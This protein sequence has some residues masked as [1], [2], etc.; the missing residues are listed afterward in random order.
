MK[1]CGKCGREINPET[2]L[3]PK[4]DQQKKNKKKIN[5]KLFLI[6]IAILLICTI[7]GSILFATG[8]IDFPWKEKISEANAEKM[9]NLV[10][11][12]KSLEENN[13]TKSEIKD[14]LNT[15]DWMKN[16]SETDDGG[17]TCVTEFGVTGVWTP[18]KENVIG[19][20]KPSDLNL[21]D[22]NNSAN[23]DNNDYFVRSIALLCPYASEDS[24]FL[25]DD[26]SFL[27][28]TMTEYANSSFT[29]FKDNEVTLDLLKHLDQYDMVWF[30]SHGALSNMFDSAWAIVDSD[31]YTMTGEFADSKTKYITLSDDFFAG[32]TIISLSSGRIGVGG[33]FYEH[34]YSDK[35][36]RNTF[37][38]FAS[39]NSMRTEKLADGLLSRGALWVEGWS[40][41]V[42]FS[43]DYGQFMYVIEGLL[44]HNTIQQSVANADKK[45][46]EDYPKIYQDD[47]KLKGKGNGDYKLKS[48]NQSTLNIEKE[49]KKA[50]SGTLSGKVVSS[51]DNKALA[52][53]NIAI[54][55]SNDSN[56]KE[57]ANSFT[58]K[59][60]N[61]EISLSA[62]EYD[63]EFTKK[64]YKA[65]T[66]GAKLDKGVI[67]VLKD[68]IVLEPNTVDFVNDKYLVKC[69]DVIY[70]VDVHGLWKNEG[71]YNKDYLTKCSATNLATDGQVI[72]YSVLNNST[73]NQYDLYQYDIETGSNEKVT[74]FVQCGVPIL[75]EGET[76]YYTDFS[77]N[78]K[79]QT[80]AHS[81]CS[82]NTST[83]E[84]KY[85]HD[86]A[87]IVKSCDG[88]I[89]Y[90]DVLGT[91][92]STYSK[93]KWGQI[94]CYDT[95]SKKT[96]M[97]SDGGVMN[98]KVI[99]GK[100]YYS[101]LYS[102]QSNTIKVCRY[103]V[104]SGKTDVLF[105]KVGKDLEI[106]DYDERYAIYTSGY[107][108]STA[109]YRVSLSSG[110]EEK[111][112]SS[113]MDGYLPH[114]AIRDN[115]RTVLYTDYSGGNVYTI[116][117]SGTKI[118]SST[119]SYKWETLLAINGETA[120]AVA[121]DNKDFTGEHSGET[122][123]VDPA[124]SSESSSYYE[125]YICCGR[126]S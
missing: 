72:Y 81:L 58:D 68:E 89:F 93:Q 98:F 97:I 46:R 86:G 39:C 42:Y 94:F 120:F 78:Y 83:G 122:M 16:V 109:F 65:H 100:L 59:D 6:P 11:K 14:Y 24:D 87:Q 2:G 7:I 60:G 23:T 91:V 5:K 57:I 48:K 3:C 4:C 35:A 102:D 103:D 30:Y 82:Y 67:T 52:D 85:I 49:M 90:R 110:K 71:G 28:D 53:V 116:D 10:E 123:F 63:F 84:K 54:Y 55:K 114:K 41:S 25:L 33:N 113:S 75:A 73:T 38:H 115:N 8:V 69:D 21:A 19:N 13:A 107:S 62:G 96:E 50:F 101:I 74:S 95:T 44:N 40:E 26:Y 56:K 106:Q 64:G 121:C 22:I 124:G 29:V 119:G 88:K 92:P 61:F 47:C 9:V 118:D 77:E 12:I 51:K 104:S 31:P 20:S 117:D 45:I 32:R 70:G 27:G 126:V 125:Y 36:L 79:S 99:S 76:I 112:S 18:E 80:L 37:F 66:T 34:Y 1:Y 15:L 108:D 17:L 111:I 43:N 105:E